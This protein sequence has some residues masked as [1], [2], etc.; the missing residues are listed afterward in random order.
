M[1]CHVVALFAHSVQVM[2][3]RFFLSANFLNSLQLL[4]SKVL[5]AE[6]KLLLFFVFAFLH[7]CT[8]LLSFSQA[9]L[10]FSLSRQNLVVVFVLQILQLACLLA[11]LFNLF[12][13]PDLLILKH[14]NTISQLLDVS[15]KL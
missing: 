9:C 13:C 6:E 5:V 2:L 10:L 8:L 12:Y 3:H 4:F 14:S 7:R 11:G 1:L 15:L